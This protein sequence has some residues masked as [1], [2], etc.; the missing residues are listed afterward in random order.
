MK[1]WEHRKA[2]GQLRRHAR[3]AADDAMVIDGRKNQFVRRS[4]SSRGESW[5]SRCDPR[6]LA[7]RR[8]AAINASVFRPPTH[9]CG[10]VRPY[11]RFPCLTRSCTTPC[12]VLPF[13]ADRSRARRC[14]R[15]NP[16]LLLRLLL[17]LLPLPLL[18]PPPLLLLLDTER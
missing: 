10:S 2:D 3:H 11:A 13:I 14:C 6:D 4:S 9:R 15:V 7:H 12:L 8:P 5:R 16:P 18:S 1:E 17:L